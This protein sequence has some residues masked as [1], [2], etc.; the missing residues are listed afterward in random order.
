MLVDEFEFLGQTIGEDA[1]VIFDVGAKYGRDT[2]Q[3]LRLFPQATIYAVDCAPRAIERL[4]DD[5]GHDRRVEIVPYALGNVYGGC[6]FP[7]HLCEPMA[8]SSSLHPVTD[9]YAQETSNTQTLQVHATTLDEFCRE[10]GIERVDLLKIDTE[11]SDLS[12]LQGAQ[13]LLSERA[14]R[15][16][17][18]ELL[19]YPYY[20]EQCWYYEV[21]EY[22]VGQ[23]YALKAMWPMYWGGRLRYAQT[24]FELSPWT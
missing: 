7:F 14:V 20:R 9:L 24:F 17:H 8:G 15:F 3:F 13:R 6:T 11:G 19:F 10:R 18:V 23:G 16:V 5:F 4:R 2:A 21:A 22:L 12:V 1:K